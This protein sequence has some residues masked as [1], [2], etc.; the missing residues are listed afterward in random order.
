MTRRQTIG[1][2]LLLI[3]AIPWLTSMHWR[4]ML[5]GGVALLAA[6]LIA[7]R[8]RFARLPLLGLCG[9]SFVTFVIAGLNREGIDIGGHPYIG[10]QLLTPFSVIALVLNERGVIRA[11]TIEPPP[12]N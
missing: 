2:S 4:P 12:A 9:V 8:P 7:V 6:M 3:A 1:A 5:I 11:E 10:M